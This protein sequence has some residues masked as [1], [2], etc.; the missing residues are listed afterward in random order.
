MRLKAFSNAVI[1]CTNKKRWGNITQ[2]Y[3]RMFVPCRTKRLLTSGDKLT[4]CWISLCCSSSFRHSKRSWAICCHNCS[5]SFLSTASSSF[6]RRSCSQSFANCVQTHIYEFQWRS[7][8]KSN[9][10]FWSGRALEYTPLNI[11]FQSGKYLT[12]YWSAQNICF[13]QNC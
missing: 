13:C 10:A 3:P 9:S 6:R 2:R 4:C 1:N 11:P 7:R 12:A 8:T 5:N